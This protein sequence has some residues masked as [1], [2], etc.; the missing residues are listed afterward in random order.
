MHFDRHGNLEGGIIQSN[1]TDLK[2]N[3]VDLF[4]TSTTRNRN[5]NSFLELIS[6]LKSEGLLEGVSCI[7]VDGSF[8]TTKVDP[9]D[10]DLI[11]LL[12]P[13]NKN[14]III[15]QNQQLIREMFI[16][17]YLDI[18]MTYDSKF[19]QDRAYI[20]KVVQDLIVDN[21]EYNEEEIKGMVVNSCDKIDYQ[22]KYWMGQFGFDRNQRSKGLISIEGGS[23]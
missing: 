2:E 23:L 7:W 16:D 9:N 8:C 18:Y 10:I 22:M 4:S 15:D 11:I 21:S 6:F 3:L 5:F 17:K 19:L 1:M 12:K 14:A 13:Y 20:E